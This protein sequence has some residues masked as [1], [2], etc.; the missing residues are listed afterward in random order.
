MEIV[1]IITLVIL[2]SVVLTALTLARYAIGTVGNLSC[3]KPKITYRVT[4]Q[5][6]TDDGWHTVILRN[7]TGK[8]QSQWVRIPDPLSPDVI[9]VKV[10]GEK[11]KR[12][13][14]PIEPKKADSC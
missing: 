3:L 10:V 8:G 5:V 11:G 12:E 9:L 2:L 1:P 7:A 4:K 6:W 13:L 14:V